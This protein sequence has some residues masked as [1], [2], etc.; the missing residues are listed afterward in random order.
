MTRITGTLHEDVC[1]FMISLN[2]FYSEKTKTRF[3]FNNM[4]PKIVPFMR[5]CG[6]IWWSQR[7]HG[8]QYSAARKNMRFA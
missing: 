2:S 5:L 8:L 6:K 3:V 4:F 7:G 1:A